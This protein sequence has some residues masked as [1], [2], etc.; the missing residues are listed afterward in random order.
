MR[1]IEIVYRFNSEDA[2]CYISKNFK[3]LDYTIKMDCLDDAITELEDIAQNLRDEH[4]KDLKKRNPNMKFDEKPTN[5]IRFPKFILPLIEYFK[6][7][8][9][10]EPKYLKGKVNSGTNNQ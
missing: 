6:K 7:K 4:I 8:D 2:K 5:K 1:L 10:Q 3:S 9:N